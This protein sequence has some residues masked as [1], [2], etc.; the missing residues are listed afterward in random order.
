MG[1]LHSDNYAGGWNPSMDV[2]NGPSVC[3]PRGDNLTLDEQGNLDLRLGQV[4]ISGAAELGSPSHQDV[5]SLFTT[6]ID[7]IRYRYAAVDHVV[8]RSDDANIYNPVLQAGSDGD[9]KFG[10]T[11]GQV[12]IARNNDKFKNDPT[13]PHNASKVW[14]V[15]PPSNAPTLSAVPSD[16]K[17]FSTFDTGESPAWT[18][19]EGGV[20]AGIGFDET[21]NGARTL[22]PATATG[23]GTMQKVF[24]AEQD[25]TE[26]DGGDTG[27]DTDLITFYLHMTLPDNLEYVELQ[28]DCNGDS[29][30][31]SARFREDYFYVQVTLD[32]A[33]S[34][35][36]D[37]AQDMDSIPSAV[38]QYKREVLRQQL[39][40]AGVDPEGARIGRRSAPQGS[41]WAKF[42]IPR[43][44]FIRVGSTPGKNWSTIKAISLTVKYAVAQ[45]SVGITPQ[46]G[47]VRVDNM[48]IAG[49]AHHPLTG[50]Y[51]VY[52]Q[53]TSHL[54]KYEAKSGI[55]PISRE[56]ELQANALRVSL[57]IPSTDY[58]WITGINFY[59]SGG[60]IPGFYRAAQA[61]ASTPGSG[62]QTFTAT[63]QISDRDIL[64]QNNP[65]DVNITTPPDDIIDIAGPFDSR[66]FCLTAE[67]VH[68][69][70]QGDPDAF[71]S[72]HVIILPGR[73]ARAMFLRNVSSE[74]ILATD[75]DFYRI[76]G[77][78]EESPDGLI[79]YI[80][81]PLNVP[82]P[83][84]DFTA[85]EGNLLIYLAAD[86]PR[87]FNGTTSTALSG[88][89]DL[90][91][92]GKTRYGISPPNMGSG[93][94]K[95]RGAIFNNR[96]FL[97]VPEGALDESSDKLWVL[98]LADSRWRRALYPIPFSCVYREPDGKIIAGTT[99]G[100]IVQ[101]EA[102][103]GLGDQINTGGTLSNVGIPV[104]FWTKS[105]NGGQ[106]LSFKEPEDFRVDFTANDSPNVQLYGDDAL[107]LS[108]ALTAGTEPI[109]NNSTMGAFKRL[110]MR[111]TGTFTSFKLFS[112]SQTFRRRPVPR[113]FWDSGFIRLGTQSL[114]H[115]RK[116]MLMARLQ[117]DLTVNVY[118]DDELLAT[119]TFI[120]DGTTT[121]FEVTLGREIYGRQM[122]VTLSSTVAGTAGTFEPYW[123]HAYFHVTGRQGLDKKFITIDGELK[124]A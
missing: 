59:L 35:K 5:H 36:L 118:M 110:Q 90:L 94:G 111:L 2:V 71:N 32:E 104:E 103:E 23:K 73:G 109:T 31:P 28:F 65:L 69:S 10:T 101:L 114:V 98:N 24:G 108:T 123:M 81:L 8:Y 85:Q 68:P 30:L 1:I 72:N 63:I 22:T 18:A 88:A 70:L 62:S 93:P 67:G 53:Y 55:S 27:V 99:T 96:L 83:I 58:G 60:T 122:R 33:V 100:T 47:V 50:K 17:T 13:D 95:F 113:L 76:V 54:A 120:S 19:V 12:F 124:A 66:L 112:W 84:S 37:P 49:G 89:T 116:L 107:L 105:D 102:R 51:K 92:Q 86:G 75:R 57:A 106:P 117:A 15:S 48:F 41:G 115:V 97:Q 21:P 14:G 46:A 20:T 29:T 121:E 80:P 91:F 79:N 38:P 43:G 56:I 9:T 82:P 16:E 44:R 25:F 6:T 64:I 3:F 34:M 45:A 40:N 26:Y 11:L 4:V 61:V 7:G 119:D 42:Q 39:E 52:A 87:V 77:N 78:G 74:P